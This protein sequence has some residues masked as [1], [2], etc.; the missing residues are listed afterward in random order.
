MQY[1]RKL[2]N[3]ALCRFFY[4]DL[5]QLRYKA[6]GFGKA[7]K[8]GPSPAEGTGWLEGHQAVP[9][10]ECWQGSAPQALGTL[11]QG[12]VH[13]HVSLCSLLAWAGCTFPGPWRGFPAH[14]ALCSGLESQNRLVHSPTHPAAPQ[15]ETQTRPCSCFPNFS[16]IKWLGKD[17]LPLLNK[18]LP[19]C[20]PSCPPHLGICR[21]HQIHLCG[22]SECSVLPPPG[23]H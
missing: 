15:H 19:P 18:S 8:A 16:L 14:P 4:P 10:W 5:K 23:H 9:W 11:C 7:L 20:W 1:K 13:W 12:V 2:P 6:S 21:N 17:H 3:A 22:N